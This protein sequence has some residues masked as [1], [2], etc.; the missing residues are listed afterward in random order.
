M[1]NYNP[2]HA[3]VEKLSEITW[4]RL[5]GM[6]FCPVWPGFRQ[7]YKL[8]KMYCDYMWK[9]SSRQGGI[10]LLY[11]QD[12]T[13]LPLFS[14]Y[15]FSLPRRD[16][17]VNYRISLK[18]SIKVHFNRPKII[19][20]YFY[21]AHY[22]NLWETATL[23][24]KRP[25]RRCF[26]VNFAKFLRTPFP[27]LRNT[28]GRLFIFLFNLFWHSRNQKLEWKKKKTHSSDD[29]AKK[30]NFP[31]KDFCSKCETSINQL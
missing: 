1:F 5:A 25:W 17:K 16:E 7:C 24:K 13:L 15:R 28:S 31:W 2:R 29:S 27:S 21:D 4:P 8:F 6:K 23:F 11:S 20:L 9:V 22:A 18:K 3:L 10:P 30:M 19:L 12:P 26:P 14:C